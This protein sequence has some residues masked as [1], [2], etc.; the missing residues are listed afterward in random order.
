MEFKEYTLSEVARIISGGT[1]KRKEEKY[2]NGDIPWLSI[3]D[4]NNDY[5][6]VY[7]TEEYITQ[8]GV[9]NSSAHIVPIGTVVISA[10]GTVGELT[11][12][13]AKMTFNQSCFGL[14]ANLDFTSNEYLYYWLK[15]KSRALKNFT[16]GSVFDTINRKTFDNI[17]INLP[18]QNNQRKVTRLLVSLD[19]KIQ[20]NNQIIANL[21]ELSQALFKHWFVDFEFPDENG[22]P[23]KSSGGEMVE[24]ELGEIPKGWEVKELKDIVKQKKETFNPKKSDVLETLHFSL[25]A[26]DNGQT[27]VLDNTK[28]IKSNK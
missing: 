14:S 16:H 21:E 10:R 1:P 8:K 9:E 11:Q 13:G 26:F 4:F 24:S 28:N 2:W 25:P 7:Q 18:N 12:V 19:N 5:R 27:P 6:M 20:K 3:K 23:Y 15:N 17:K 22:N